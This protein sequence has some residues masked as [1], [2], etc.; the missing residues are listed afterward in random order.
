MEKKKLFYGWFVLVLLILVAA[1]PMAMLMNTFSYY[2][3][4]I[5]EEFGCTYFQFS[6]CNTASTICNIL[7]G[8]LLASKL[9]GK[10]T[11]YWMAIGA[12]LAGICMWLIGNVNNVWAVVGLK[13]L[14]DFCFSAVSYIPINLLISEWF[15]DK[16]ATATSIVMAGLGIGGTV[17]TP[18][19]S[20]LI[21][22]SWRLSIHI[23]AIVVVVVPLIAFWFLK[24]PAEVGTSPLMPKA[25]EKTGTETSA[26]PIW[27]GLTKKQAL[28]TAAFFIYALVCI[29]CG[30][31]A[32][33]VST[34]MPAFF[35]EN[36]LN[37]TA[38]MT[39]FNFSYMIGFLVMGVVID[40]LGIKNGGTL[41]CA[42]LLV[43]LLALFLAPSIP[44]AGYI[45][46]ILY[47]LG[48]SI[49]SLAPPLLASATFGT[50]E[51][52]AIYGLGNSCFMLGCTIG[53][54]LSSAIRTAA[55]SYASAWITL[56]IF[57]VLLLIGIYVCV[58][59]GSKLRNNL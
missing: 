46:V 57:V 37:Y 17:L 19:V 48:M 8:I 41:T 45:S 14:A 50:K 10:N 28:K 9:N 39:I 40:K 59:K 27:E 32:A 42:M 44:T 31:A 12:V 58:A 33:G 52:G 30:A 29:C 15:V 38:L 36:G 53:P 51:Y 34:Q 43:G 18:V 6:L 55:G 54:L 4:P 7:F 20:K 35:S 16:R 56:I 49:T 24:T 11:R 1:G 21:E 22:Q 23:T 25:T 3:V 13:G 2:Q 5:C 26:A 47:P